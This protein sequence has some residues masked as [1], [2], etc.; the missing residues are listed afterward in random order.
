MLAY[1]ELEI[2]SIDFIT[3]YEASIIIENSGG[4]LREILL[5][6][7]YGFIEDSLNLIRKIYQNCPLIEY[8]SLLFSSTI[9]NFIELEKLLKIVEI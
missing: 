4:H 3:L 2:F 6:Y 7:E 8:L 9:E 1:H 5:R